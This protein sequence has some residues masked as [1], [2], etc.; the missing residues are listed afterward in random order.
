MTSLFRDEIDARDETYRFIRDDPDGAEAKAF[1]ERL[2]SFFAPYADRSFRADIARCFPTKFW[3]MYLAFGL[4]KQGAKLE[5]ILSG[6]QARGSRN[7]PDLRLSGLT[8]S[9][10]VEATVAF[11]GTGDNRVPKECIGTEQ[12]I[13]SDQLIL[14][15]LNRIDAK[16]KQ[17]CGHLRRGIVKDTDPY[18]IAI[19]SRSLSF[20]RYEPDL[21]RIVQALF[22][23]GNLVATLHRTM[24]GWVG[25]VDYSYRDE[26]KTK[27]G[28]P[29]PTN[30]FLD[31]K[32]EGISA[33][34][35]GP[36]DVWNLPPNEAQIG[37][38]CTLIHN[39]MARNKIPHRWLK[40]GREYWVEDNQ[41][42]INAWYKE[43]PSYTGE[44][45]PVRSLEEHLQKHRARRRVKYGDVLHDSESVSKDIATLHDELKGKESE[46]DR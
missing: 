43:H 23:F 27:L 16:F 19:N 39:S 37:L 41:L 46:K 45:E 31:Q 21:Q 42:V 25:S 30:V 6:R 40:C 4:A 38:D 14:R 29:V 28:E 32:Y 2:W 15:Y 36:S 3:E 12:D 44:T 13:P 24:E 8:H 10:W 11:D 9:V 17:L 7:G 34:L 26:I 18:I 20:A 33:V 35:F 5:P 22:P 1:V